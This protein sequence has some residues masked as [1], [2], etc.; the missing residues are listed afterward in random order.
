MSLLLINFVLSRDV[1]VIKRS[2]KLCM[3]GDGTLCVLC[4][5][6]TFPLLFTSCQFAKKTRAVAK[7]PEIHYEHLELVKYVGL[8]VFI[9]MKIQVTVFW[10]VTLCSDVSAHSVTTQRNMT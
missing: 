8:E 5:E 6:Y 3:Y 9:V 7:L 1:S 2:S 10:V 4:K